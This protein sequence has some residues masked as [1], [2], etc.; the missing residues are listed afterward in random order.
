MKPSIVAL[1][2]AAA[3]AA[4]LPVGS[5][6]PAYAVD[7]TVSRTAPDLADVRAM[8][9][10]KDY[11]GALVRLTKLAD[12]V[13]H[14]DVYNLMGFAYRKSGDYAKASTFYLK[15]LDFEPDHKGALEY[16]GELFLETGQ[17]AKAQAN[18]ARLVALCPQGCEERED[19]AEAI[20]KVAPPVKT[21]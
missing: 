21:N 6:G 18:L 4:T 8:I 12:T 1:A 10:A 7:N 20:A 3:L 2:L 13:Q 9:K 14:A 15:A 19:L 5:T 16:Q 17:M 11:A